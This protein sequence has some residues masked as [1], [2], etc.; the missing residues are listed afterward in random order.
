M[1][2]T[3]VVF[4]FSEFIMQAA[5]SSARGGQVPPEAH[6][7]RPDSVGTNKSQQRQ[8]AGRDGHTPSHPHTDSCGQQRQ[9]VS[10]P[11]GRQGSTK[12]STCSELE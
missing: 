4:L 9:E 5:A 3:Q 6:K 7:L 8:E 11:A 12:L 10:L 2:I 1:N